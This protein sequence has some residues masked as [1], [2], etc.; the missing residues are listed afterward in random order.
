MKVVITKPFTYYIDG[1]QRRDFQ[2]G[3][4]DVPRDCAAYAEEAGFTRKQEEKADADSRTRNARR[5]KSTVPN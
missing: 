5:S 1:Y 4:Y 3:E 2:I